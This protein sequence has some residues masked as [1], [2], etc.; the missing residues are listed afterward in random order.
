MVGV[1]WRFLALLAVCGSLAACG[2]STRNGQSGPASGTGGSAG[3]GSSGGTGQ[4]GVAGQL[5]GSGGGGAPAAASHGPVPLHRLRGV[6]YANSVRDLLG[7][8]ASAPEPDA[9]KPYD[10][11]ITDAAPWVEAISLVAEQLLDSPELPEHLLCVPTIDADRPCALAVIDDLGLRAFRRP[12]RETEQSRLAQLYDEV[13]QV[14]GARVAIEQVVRALLL[15]PEFLFHLEPSDDPDGQGPELL[16]S[17]ALAARLSF[18]LW[19]TTPD[20]QLLEAAAA[21]LTGDD[22]LSAAYERLALDPRSAE[23]ADGLN[24][25]WLGMDQLAAH[26]VDASVFPAWSEQLRQDMASSQRRL[27]QALVSPSQPLSSLLTLDVSQRDGLL[28]EPAV[29]TLTSTD[30]RTSATHRGAF[31]VE[32]LL[33]KQLPPPHPDISAALGADYPAGQSERATLEA[34]TK[35]TICAACHGLFDPFGLALGNY[36]AIGQFRTVDSQGYPVDTRVELPAELLGSSVVVGGLSDLNSALTLSSLFPACAAQQVASYLIH[37]PLSAET[38]PDL[39]DPLG[40]DVA[41]G[42]SLAGISRMV[43]MSDQFRY[44]LLPAN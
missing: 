14:E 30:R 7:I 33:C 37:R 42:A 35:E 20:P 3:S 44:R 17:Y 31:I 6:E 1:R 10:A 25:V 13:S 21:D 12:L 32:R 15:S 5:S 22:A 43:V 23:L 34:L 4:A 11:V 28:G 39:L 24:S 2:R 38:D 27:M 18:A 29:L 40:A 26:A 41:A 8:E 9:A 19:S 36:D 16:D